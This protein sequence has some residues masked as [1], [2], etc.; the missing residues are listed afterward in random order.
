[1]IK[2][3]DIEAAREKLKKTTEKTPKKTLQSEI[4]KGAPLRKTAPI[5]K[6]VT[7]PIKESLSSRIK[8]FNGPVDETWEDTPDEVEKFEKEQNT[9]TPKPSSVLSNA[10]PQKDVDSSSQENT[11]VES[12]TGKQDNEASIRGLEMEI[13][14]LNQ[15]VHSKDRKKVKKLL[16]EKKM[17]L[18]LLRNPLI[19]EKPKTPKLDSSRIK[20]LANKLKIRSNNLKPAENSS[21]ST[22][23]K[24]TII[25]KPDVKDSGL[26][27]PKKSRPIIKDT[28][29]QDGEILRKDPPISSPDEPEQP[30]IHSITDKKTRRKEIKTLETKSDPDKSAQ[31]RALEAQIQRL[32]MELKNGKGNPLTI[33][34][35]LTKRN[36]EIDQLKPKPLSVERKAK[37]SNL[38]S[39]LPTIVNPSMNKTIE[40]K[41][42]L[43]KE[44]STMTAEPDMKD[45]VLANPQK[46]NPILKDITVKSKDIQ[47]KIR[48]QMPRKTPQ[49]RRDPPESKPDEPEQPLIYKKDPITHK[50]SIGVDTTVKEPDRSVQ[51]RAVEGQIRKL[52]LQLKNGKADLSDIQ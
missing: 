35:E 21:P 31:I 41:V 52:E 40:K 22:T 43:N 37:N 15:R 2:K 11:K 38:I 6:K 45:S 16:K 13:A 12:K 19:E 25:A 8:Q 49:L 7:N 20:N 5:Q 26:K 3:E 42:I 47:E 9:S 1:M 33:Q 28:N 27:N 4:L 32:E 14:L 36:K 50:K 29:V 30:L 46:S 48:L 24:S 34:A 23:E 51:I 44:K 18:D 39:S 17:R 10:Q